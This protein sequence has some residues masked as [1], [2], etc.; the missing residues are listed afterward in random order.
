VT[1]L[2]RQGSSGKDLVTYLFDENLH[3]RSD[4][5]SLGYD[6]KDESIGMKC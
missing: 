1:A 6:R 2:E 3:R 5:M 4:D